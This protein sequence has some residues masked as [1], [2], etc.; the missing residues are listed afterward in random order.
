VRVSQEKME[1]A[2]SSFRSEL[3]EN[4]QNWV[5]AVLS[6]VDQRTQGVREEM[7]TKTDT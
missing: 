3:E 5:E 2:I 6:S 4:A 1:T 7:N